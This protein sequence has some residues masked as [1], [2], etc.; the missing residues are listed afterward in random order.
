MI[1]EMERTIHKHD[2]IKTAVVSTRKAGAVSQGIRQPAPAPCPALCRPE[3]VV[4]LAALRGVTAKWMRVH[5]ACASRVVRAINASFTPIPRFALADPFRSSA[6]THT[7][8]LN[9]KIATLKTDMRARTRD[10]QTMHGHISVKEV[11]RTLAFPFD[12]SRVCAFLLSI[13]CAVRAALPA[14][15]CRCSHSL[16]LLETSAASASLDSRSC[17]PY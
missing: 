4:L 2:T 10:L 3:C 11:R 13:S 14:F 9:K 15:P 12:C 8:A 6:P 7:A 16:S 1:Q 5:A 17:L